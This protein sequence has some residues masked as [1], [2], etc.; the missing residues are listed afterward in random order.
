MRIQNIS[1][2]T[3]ASEKKININKYLLSVRYTYIFV[4]GITEF[5]ICS[6]LKG[7]FNNTFRLFKLGP[8]LCL[9]WKVSSAPLS[10]S[11]WAVGILLYLDYS[12]IIYWTFLSKIL[13][14]CF[15]RSF[16]FKT[17]A[18]QFLFIPVSFF[19]SEYII[20]RWL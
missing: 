10:R 8:C 3:K 18:I 11:A 14:S 1:I 13:S 9:P 16:F 15:K 7:N 4:V 17:S 19:L 20:F 12:L 2:R 5:L 6:I